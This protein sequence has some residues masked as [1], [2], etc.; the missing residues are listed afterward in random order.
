MKDLGK[1]ISCVLLLSLASLV[2]FFTSDSMPL[3]WSGL[4]RQIASLAPLLLTL[5]RSCVQIWVLLWLILLLFGVLLV[6]CSVSPL[7]GHTWRMLFNRSVFICMIL[8]SHIL[9]H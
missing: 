8:G 9:L 2:V 5:R 7:S 6:P 1:P 4:G 3:S